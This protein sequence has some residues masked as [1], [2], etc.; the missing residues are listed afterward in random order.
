MM[1]NLEER[2]AAL[3]HLV[4]DVI[5]GGLKKANDEYIDEER[6]GKFQEDYG[7]LLEPYVKPMKAIC[8]ED[9]DLSRDLYDFAKTQDGYGTEGFDEKS[10][11]DNAIESIKAK[12]SLIKDVSPEDVEVKVEVDTDTDTKAE[13][14]T[15]DGEKEKDVPSVEELSELYDKAYSK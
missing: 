6:Y 10:I 4:N 3:E 7:T 12:M 13:T 8:G 1:E 9:Y 5:I 15:E 14:E 11:I 2:V